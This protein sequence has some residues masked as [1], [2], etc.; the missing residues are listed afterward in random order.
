MT[1]KFKVSEKQ[2]LDNPERRAFLPPEETL[3]KLGLQP[4]EI[5]ADIGCGIGYF[6]FP[7]ASIVGPNVKVFALDVAPE[8]LAEVELKN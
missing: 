2:K 4:G 8:M 1:H 3:R 5:M 7:A 6:T